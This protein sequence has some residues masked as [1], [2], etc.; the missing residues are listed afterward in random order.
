M[1]SG[2]ASAADG[3]GN[4]KRERLCSGMRDRD[5][6]EIFT[7]DTVRAYE[8][9]QRE[10]S[11]NEVVFEY[12]CFKLRQNNRVDALLCSYRSEYLQ[13]TEGK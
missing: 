6:K 5:G 1:K 11:L 13:V 10:W 2:A 8:L 7:Q 4:M 12:G 9:S 3:G